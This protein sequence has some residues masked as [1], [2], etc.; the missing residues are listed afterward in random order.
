MLHW[1][2][3]FRVTTRV[4]T[5]FASL[6]IFIA[7]L[8]GLFSWTGREMRFQVSEYQ[9]VAHNTL[10]VTRTVS[11][12]GLIR[13]NVLSYLYSGNEADAKAVDDLRRKVDETLTELISTTRSETRKDRYRRMQADMAAYTAAFSQVR[14]LKQKRT[15]LYTDSLRPM[16]AQGNDLLV[17]LAGSAL[18]SGDAG[19][20]LAALTLREHFEH[21]RVA[22]LEFWAGPTAALN[23]TA[24]EEIAGFREEV[25]KAMEQI[26]DPQLKDTASAL[27]A[28]TRR[29]QGAFSE[30][31][32]IALR[33]QVLA[34]GTMVEIATEFYAIGE[35]AL[36]DGIS[37]MSE[38]EQQTTDMLG[39][40]AAQ[41]LVLAAVSL[42]LGT[43][44]ATTMAIGITRPLRAM[45]AA[46]Q[47]LAAHD[48]STPIPA[49]DYRDEIGDM[50]AAMAVFRDR[51]I[52]ADRLQAEQQ[53]EHEK[54]LSRAAHLSDLAHTFDTSVGD[55]LNTIAAAA[56]TLDV[57]AQGM[58][59]IAEETSSQAHAVSDSAGE[60]SENVQTVASAA[61]ELGASIREISRQV[62]ESS[63][64][65]ADASA[66]AA[67]ANTVIQGLESA[68][69]E[70]GQVVDLITAIADQTNLLALNATIEAARAGDAG[71]G[72]AVVA[73]E[74]KSLATQT[75]RAT[76][77]IR[78]Q[79]GRI[80]EEVTRAAHA[81]DD[82]VDA[83]RD[84]ST[85]ASAI[86]SAVE[87][88]SAATQEISL[89]VQRAANSTGTVSETIRSVSQAAQE[90]GKASS[91]VLGASRN[92]HAE[93]EALQKL[94]MQFLQDVRAA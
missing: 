41:V 52:D 67:E 27:L 12:T 60:V 47:R 75:G 40:A 71:K 22:T 76:D 11:D 8:T 82:I 10:T 2:S 1:M 74:V 64:R 69:K 50:A 94:V 89:N 14:S 5:A 25:S 28:L 61:E 86:A 70:I 43:V 87:E 31:A 59:S 57:T 63:N 18:T 30:F 26:S 56:G 39:K 85:I 38:V 29:Y 54:R 55:L 24:T 3:R 53:A 36:A 65:S 72:F 33:E 44:F 21:A 80:Q 46:M 48:L 90:T 73:N 15:A 77:Q 20:A 13:R 51:M 19:A 58:S 91:D 62:Q 9:R 37:R 17:R 84:A 83:A 79:I 6:L 49:T 45:T 7:L 34:T 16:L 23:T 81:I 32:G 78:G 93:A 92:L 35:E 66:R 88:Q 4:I 68:A 42:I